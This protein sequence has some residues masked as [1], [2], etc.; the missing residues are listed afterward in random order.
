M[1]VTKGSKWL[2]YIYFNLHFVELIWMD[3]VIGGKV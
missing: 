3:V 2:N 1:T